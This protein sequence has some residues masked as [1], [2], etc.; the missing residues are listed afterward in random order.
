MKHKH[1]Y[2]IIFV[3][4]LFAQ[5]QDFAGIA[6]KQPTPNGFSEVI[7]PFYN[8][9]FLVDVKKLSSE[10]NTKSQ[11]YPIYICEINTGIIYFVDYTN[12]GTV[13]GT[14]EFY[15]SLFDSTTQTWVKPI[16]LDKEYLA[17]CEYNKKMNYEE[18]FLTIDNDIYVV[19]LK[20]ASFDPQKLN[21]NT[22]GV[23]SSPSLSPDGNTLYFISDR[24]GSIGG[25]D[26]W[27]SERLTNGN[28]SEPF[29]LGTEVNSAEDEESPFIMLDGVTLYFS[30][31]GHATFG[32]YDI[33]TST[34]NDDGY[35]ST[36]DQLKAPV[37]S[38]SDD[39][40]YIA[41]SYGEHAYYSSEKLEKGNQDIFYVNYKVANN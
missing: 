4:S 12:N 33:F 29:N 15:F 8:P 24:K 18:I 5:K 41:D 13:T 39:F 36:P 25:K 19:N 20:N 9:P 26:V 2:I 35:W 3:L 10:I 11:E 17:F 38:T 1:I 30:S 22:K 16:N 28:W 7:L 34:Q 32:G 27:A 31:K 37:N 6:T 14:R 21:I 23:E 40:Y